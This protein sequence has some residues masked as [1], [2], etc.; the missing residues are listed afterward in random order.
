[1]SDAWEAVASIASE[2]NRRIVAFY[3]LDRWYSYAFAGV[4]SGAGALVFFAVAM[5]IAAWGFQLFMW[6]PWPDF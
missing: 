5:W 3:E 6:L 1:M 2:A 4:F